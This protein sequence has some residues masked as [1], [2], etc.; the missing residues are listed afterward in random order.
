MNALISP[1]QQSLLITKW[2]LV[3]GM[4]K[5]VVEPI[6]D[7]ARI[8]EVGEVAFEVALPLFWVACA[9]DVVA[10]QYWYNTVDTSINKI[11]NAPY[12]QLP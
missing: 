2:V 4:Y 9:D 1:Q 7:S 8:C 10:D 12:P 3:N 6:P 5:P 11:D